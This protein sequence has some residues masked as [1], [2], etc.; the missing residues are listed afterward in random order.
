MRLENDFYTCTRFEGREDGFSLELRLNPE[1]AIFRGHFPEKA[2]VPGVCTLS[3]VRE[4]LERFLGCRMRFASI[5][6]CKFQ[7]AGRTSTNTAKITEQCSLRSST[8]ILQTKFS[9]SSTIIGRISQKKPQ[10]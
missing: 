2:V 8:K 5:K 4:Q 10:S 7:I 1:H 9:K 6:E 3:I